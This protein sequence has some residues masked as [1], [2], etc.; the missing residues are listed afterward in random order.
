MFCGGSID[1]IYSNTTYATP[2]MPTIDPA[3]MRRT[4]SWRR[5]DPTKI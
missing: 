5:I 4:W 1:G 2:T 3:M